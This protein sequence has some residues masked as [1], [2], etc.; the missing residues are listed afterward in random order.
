MFILNFLV[1]NVIVEALE[2]FNLTNIYIKWP[3]DILSDGKK[4]AGILIENTIKSDGGFQS[5]IGIGINVQSINFNG[6]EHAS[7]ITEQ[8][9]VS[10]DREELLIKIVDLL[11]KRIPII[12]MMRQEEKER[13]HSKLFKK[14]IVSTFETLDGNYFNA[15]INGVD[16]EGRL[17]LT[18]QSGNLRL[19]GLKEVRLL[20]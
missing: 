8:N 13:Y 7:S 18:D 6:I 2:S 9:K 15:I 12:E 3:N 14:D 20:Y 1:S 17:M 5:I 11:S 4:I 19:Y 16:H 10:I